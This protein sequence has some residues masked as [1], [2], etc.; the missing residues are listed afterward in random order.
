M[1]A[2]LSV[3]RCLHYSSAIQ[4]FGTAAF[5][6]WIASEAL[7]AKL[8][9]TSRRIAIFNAWLL[10]V[11]AALWLCLEAGEMGDGWADTVNP[12]V[13][14]LVIVATNFGPVWIANIVLAALAVVA[15][16]AL[17][18]RKLSILAIVSTLALAALAFVGHAAAEGGLFSALSE[19]SQ[20]IHLLSSGFWFGSLLSL[21]LVLRLIRNPRYSLDVD[22][23]LRRFSGLGHAAV[24]LALASGLANIWL[25]LRDTQIGLSATYQVLLLIKVI[26]VRSM[27]VLALVNPLCVRACDTRG[28]PRRP[29]AQR[30]YD[31]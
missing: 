2:A 1:E 26:L 3:V 10:L 27:C 15:A 17:G 5:E 23:A 22:L 30:R 11:S 16:H 29:E 24:A 14:W 25:V 7:S 9:S 28:R 21:V 20:V 19:T 8:L 18:P 12:R 6:T 31:C 4:L 13:V